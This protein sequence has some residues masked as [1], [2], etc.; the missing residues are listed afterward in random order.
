MDWQSKFTGGKPAA[1]WEKVFESPPRAANRHDP[2]ACFS[3]TE[4]WTANSAVGDATI[5]DVQPAMAR[6][7]GMPRRI[8]V[9]NLCAFGFETDLLRRI[10]RREPFSP[11]H[12][13]AFRTAQS[14]ALKAT[15]DAPAVRMARAYPAA[16]GAI[17]AGAFHRLPEPGRSP[18]RPKSS[19]PRGKRRSNT[20]RQL[21]SPAIPGRIPDSSNLAVRCR[22]GA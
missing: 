9:H 20:P 7:L 16:P 21:P 12:L 5:Y 22:L 2:G 17:G 19:R 6:S 8:L 15:A 18:L 4:A 13:L 11:G 3:C 14:K 1:W 10:K